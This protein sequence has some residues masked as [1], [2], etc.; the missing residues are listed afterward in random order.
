MRLGNT[1]GILVGICVGKYIGEY[2]G[3]K[4]GF[5]VGTSDGL[6]ATVG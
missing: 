4:E 3:R 1:E 5:I 6:E 2:V